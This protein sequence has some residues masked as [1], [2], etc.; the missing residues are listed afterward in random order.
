MSLPVRRGLIMGLWNSHTSVG[1]ILGSLIAGY[2][3]S[4]NW[5]L[6]FI[7][8]GLIIAFMG[9]VCFLF[10]IEREFSLQFLCLTASGGF[11]FLGKVLIP[12]LMLCNRRWEFWAETSCTTFLFTFLH[13]FLSADPNDLKSM[14]G[15]N[16]SPGNTVS[17]FFSFSESFIFYVSVTFRILLYFY[18]TVIHIVFIETWRWLRRLYE[19]VFEC[20]ASAVRSSAP[21]RFHCRWG[22]EGWTNTSSVVVAVLVILLC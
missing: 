21:K 12:K 20:F 10:L 14:S 11:S 19:L 15:Q 3:V 18:F 1:N 2:W 22:W 6:S 17:F 7:V 8:P 9:V 4:S 16:S 5:G 13:L